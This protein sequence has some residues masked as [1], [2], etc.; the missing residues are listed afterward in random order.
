[1][2]FVR[3]M[4]CGI[5]A[6]GL[7]PEPLLSDSGIDPALLEQPSARVTG[8][9]YV[10][11]FRLLIER[12]DDDG[13]GFY[14]RRLRRGSFPLIVR[15]TLGSP[16]LGVAIRRMSRTFALL[17]DDVELVP[18]RQGSLAGLGL[19]FS[20]GNAAHPRFM[21][22]MLLR[23]FWR[24]LAW[25][26]A[27][28]LP[29]ARFDLAFECPP[30]VGSHRNVLPGEIRFDAPLSAFWVDAEA[31]KLPI[32]RDEPALRAFIADVQ[33]N[34]VLPR[35]KDDD[36]S[37]RVRMHLQKTMPAWPD[38][39]STARALHMSVS[40]LQRHLMA[41]RTTFQAL[42]DELR[43]DLAINRLNTSAVPLVALAAELG[44]S[45]SAAFQRAFKCWTGSPPGAYR[46]RG[47]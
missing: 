42:K 40:T 33:W 37:T 15:S 1:M 43:R 27:V 5:Q 8:E 44:F 11:L 25:L 22:E 31:L 41:E 21:H 26:V 18:L 4:V 30:Y 28:R 3:G 36:V 7:S 24:V 32:R 14:S 46:R 29:V 34:I 17:Q 2:A 9:Q 45:D 20:A 10:T 13:L 23:I 12:F 38:L 47:T 6:R 19:R 39:A 35:R 16:D